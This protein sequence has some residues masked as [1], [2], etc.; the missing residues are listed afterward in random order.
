MSIDAPYMLA[1]TFLIF[2]WYRVD[3]GKR[4]FPRSALLNTA[5]VA[6]SP[7]GL[8]YYLFRSRGIARG[9]LAFGGCLTL[10]IAAIVTVVAIESIVGVPASIE[11]EQAQPIHGIAGYR[12][13][14]P[15]R[16][17]LDM[18][19]DHVQGRVVLKVLIGTTGRP[20]SVSVET[21]SGHHQLDDAAID[22][23][24]KS[25]FN[26]AERDGHPESSF[27]LVP[28]DFKLKDVD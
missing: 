24:W 3:A 23:T 25:E 5:V 2:I 9:A 21:S 19:R 12:K 7:F 27:A 4:G 16:Y 8:T 11:I 28:V 13:F 6:A 26:P 20:E 18:V 14:S 1:A 17:P 22:A 15:P 10:L